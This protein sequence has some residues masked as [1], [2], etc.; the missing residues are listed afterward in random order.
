MSG[1]KIVGCKSC[2]ILRSEIRSVIFI[3][4][5]LVALALAGCTRPPPIIKTQFKSPDGKTAITL[6]HEEAAG[7]LDSSMFLTIGAPNLEF[8]STQL[9]AVVKRGKDVE[10]YWT[11]DGRPIISVREFYGTLISGSNRPSFV[12]CGLS[13]AECRPLLPPANDRQILKLGTYHSGE[14]EPF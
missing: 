6:W 9:S 12:T 10:S 3:S 7:T 4:L 11:A 13:V 2:R 1:L 8:S 14:S 5:G